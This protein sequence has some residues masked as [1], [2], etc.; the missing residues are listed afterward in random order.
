MYLAYHTV[1]FDMYLELMED[2]HPGRR[3]AALFIPFPPQPARLHQANQWTAN[4]LDS[5]K[6]PP[7]LND[8]RC[9]FFVAPNDDISGMG[10]RGG[11]VATLKVSLTVLV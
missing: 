11:Q 4:R 6:L 7:I 9:L 2:L 8:F 1:G 3:M 10:S 5:N